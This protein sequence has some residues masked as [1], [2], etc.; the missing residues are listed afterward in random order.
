MKSHSPSWQMMALVAFFYSC[1][2]NTQPPSEVLITEFGFPALSVTGTISGAVIQAIVPFGANATVLVATFAVS[3]GATVWVNGITQTSGV[4]ANDFTDPVTYSVQAADGT[5]Q[6]YTVTVGRSGGFVSETLSS[7]LTPAPYAID[8]SPAGEFG[9]NGKTWYVDCARGGD[10]NAG[11]SESQAFWSIQKGIDSSG[12]G[13]KIYVMNGTYRFSKD[14]YGSSQFLSHSGT[15][16]HWI[17]LA[18]YPGHRPKLEFADYQAL[19]IG[20]SDYIIVSGFTI[21]GPANTI[22]ETEALAHADTTDDPRYLSCGITVAGDWRYEENTTH[23]LH[24]I[25]ANNV[26]YDCSGAGITAAWADYITI[27]SNVV[28]KCC[29]W[30]PFNQSGIDFFAFYDSNAADTGIHNRISENLCYG[31][32]CLI[33]FIADTNTPK[34]I[35]DGNGLT[36]DCLNLYGYTGSTI[37]EN[38]I[39]FDNGAEGINI[40]R[41]DHL[42]IRNNTLYC[43]LYRPDFQAGDLSF[44]NSHDDGEPTVRDITVANNVVFSRNSITKSNVHACFI[45][46]TDDVSGFEFA[47]NLFYGVGSSPGWGL[48]PGQ[49]GFPETGDIL[50]ADPEFET[51][52]VD[53]AVADFSLLAGSP[54]LDKC[55]DGPAIDFLGHTR[56]AGS[57]D[58]GALER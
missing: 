23:S 50:D 5:T 57:I 6:S 19:Y 15:A 47:D 14:A 44:W 7:K 31:N 28:A 36:V 29:F 13:D 40:T 33:P 45:G 49:A 37:I 2:H 1:G 30:N 41:S 3:D 24:V 12:P 25:I 4:T 51:A 35:T 17:L 34:R 10:S 20:A 26:V 52:S 11:D 53:P 46:T 42:V 54:A 32:N 16:A 8:V 39:C 48:M 22:T 9:L 43:N 56:S 55:A 21:Q 27:R 58:M 18:A 38:N